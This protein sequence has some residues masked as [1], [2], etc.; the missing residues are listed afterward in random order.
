MRQ[1]HLEVTR[2][3]RYAL[4]GDPA[5]ADTL[6]FVIHGHGQLAAI[7]I[8]HFE[9]L[10]DGTRC[11]VAPE[12]LNRFYA[13]P[14]SWRGAGQARVGATWMTRE[15]REAEM[16]DYIR[17]LDRLH[18]HIG[19]EAGR[20]LPL[21]VL[22]FS[23]GVA[24]AARWICRGAA[25][26]QRVILWAGPLPPELDAEAVAPLRAARLYRVL[27]DQDDM[28]TPDAVAAEHE[29]ERA[30]GLEPEHIVFAGGHKMDRSVLARLA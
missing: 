12:A 3:A 28:A 17:Y 16:A 11:I 24:T 27:G 2:T 18:R 29:R 23:Q 19:A 21:T 14:T 9:A 15:D 5:R 8:R 1:H 13:E 6:W 20:D 7:F 22:G 10:D 25:R 26:P 30:L 4:L